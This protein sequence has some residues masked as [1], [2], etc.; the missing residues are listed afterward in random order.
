MSTSS[1][2]GLVS[3]LLEKL[4]HAGLQLKLKFPDAVLAAQTT[5]PADSPLTEAELRAEIQ[6]LISDPNR[7]ARRTRRWLLS[8]GAVA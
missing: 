8:A 4:V 7:S 6:Q 5:W 2:P 3:A 1:T